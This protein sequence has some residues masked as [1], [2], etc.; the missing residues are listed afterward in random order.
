MQTVVERLRRLYAGVV[1]DTM[2]FDMD[3]RNFTPGTT[4]KPLGRHAPRPLVGPAFTCVGQ[5]LA[6]D[7]LLD[8]SVRLTMLQ[9]MTPGCVQ[10][11]DGG[12]DLSVAHYGDI[13]ARLA[14]KAGAVGA[15]IR[16][17][18]RDARMIR[19]IKFPVY[20][21]GVTPVDAYGRWQI[22]AWQK[23]I[24]LSPTVRAQPNDIIFADNDGVLVIPHAK[25]EQI[26]IHAEARAVIEDKIRADLEELTPE[27][28]YSRHGRW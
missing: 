6:D 23:P 24:W 5:H 14:R 26:C 1:Y 12:D 4:I 27:A 21:L 22:R 13:S 11:I 10:V 19:Q 16:G 9:E 20:C 18:T 3:L 8:D 2:Y 17:H 7:K 15:V 28:L 25:A